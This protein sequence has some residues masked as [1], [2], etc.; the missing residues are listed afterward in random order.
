MSTV[1]GVANHTPDQT[2]LWLKKRFDITPKLVTIL[3]LGTRLRG[4]HRNK[5]KTIVF[6]LT[7]QD[8]NY[9]KDILRNNIVF[10]FSSPLRLW[11]YKGII[12]LDYK[13]S[14]DPQRHGIQLF[15][16]FFEQPDLD[17]NNGD[18]VKEPNRTYLT[19]IL[20]ETR[21][22]GSL[23][24]PLMTFVYTT[25]SS[26]HQKPIKIAICQWLYY[27]GIE[28]DLLNI[29]D[30]IDSQIKL[31]EK[32]KLKLKDLLLSDQG[33][34]YRAAFTKLRQA[35]EKGVAIPY[36]QLTKEFEVSGFEMRYIKS[37]IDTAEKTVSNVSIQDIVN[38][39]L[40][41]KPEHTA[42]NKGKP[43]D[44]SNT[45]LASKNNVKPTTKPNSQQKKSKD[46]SIEVGH[47]T[48]HKKAS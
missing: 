40:K 44:K 22:F 42:L 39:M 21:S 17:Q 38:K 48:K 29:I 20:E 23:L 2:Y 6:C 19:K 16:E 26:T 18:V 8:F 3:P 5:L 12:A 27:G 37:V 36:E 35:K 15:N 34:R 41:R 1:Y 4:K 47:K 30:S 14:D 24:R 9:N 46:Q 25:P 11:E 31:T 32:H 45:K 13:E 28:K 7:Y 10:I 33:D 43:E